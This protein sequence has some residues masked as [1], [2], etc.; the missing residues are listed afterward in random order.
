[1]IYGGGELIKRT[2]PWYDASSKPA[3]GSLS[4]RMRFISREVHLSSHFEK[5]IR[6]LLIYGSR[7][8]NGG[9]LGFLGTDAEW[10]IGGAREKREFSA[11]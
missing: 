8:K 1:M 6:G 3:R 4:L 5:I 11:I 2:R 10:V 9:P 7:W